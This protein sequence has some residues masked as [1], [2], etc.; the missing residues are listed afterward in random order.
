MTIP[1]GRQNISKSDIDSVVKVLK[2]DF[3]TQG[4]VVNKFEEEIS[5]Y[6]NS[7]YAVASN[8]AT[9][10]LHIACLALGINKND[11]VW[12]SAISFVASANCA[13]YCGAK[14][15]FID[16]DK[17]SFNISIHHLEKKLI[18][19]KQKN[20]LPKA[21]IA[22]HMCGQ[23]CD[24]KRIF[25]LSKKYNFKIIEDASHAIG[26]S[27]MGNKIGS[28]RFSE[29]VVFS[30]HPVKVITS[31][32]GGIATTN[33]KDLFLKMKSLVTHGITRDSNQIEISNPEP[34][35]YEQQMLGFNYR[36]TDIH[37][38]LGLNQLKRLDRFVEKRNLLASRYNSLLK[39]LPIN[40]PKISKKCKSAY[41]LY[42]IQ[43]NKDM[44][45]KRNQ[46]FRFLRKHGIGV[47]LHYMP[48]YRQPY[49]KRSQYFKELFLP[50]S[51]DYFNASISIPIHTLLTAQ[52]Q[53]YIV[54]M[55]KFA[56]NEANKNN[57]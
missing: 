38:A 15:D 24:M 29:I 6:T 53:K 2:S 47:N 23:S 19:A 13:L 5:N 11:I 39:D 12:T 33:N 16:I 3:I 30:F 32:E 34:W 7:K 50:N 27:Y 42:V 51:E 44:S 41:H 56:L 25:Q 21:L 22:V 28:C 17:D 37:A 20:E 36:M 57:S 35:Y 43:L 54:K 55:I 46:V 49:Y 40:V 14:I 31:G 1:Y 9:S 10:S 52:E 45:N 18:K 26:G 48:I 4:P 8:S